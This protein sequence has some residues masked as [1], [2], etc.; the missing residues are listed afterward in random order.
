MIKE[1]FIE[2]DRAWKGSMN[3]P[4]PLR[5]IGGMALVLQYDYKRVTKDAD[6]IEVDEIT[7]QIKSDILGIAGK[8][9]KLHKKYRLY[10]EFLKK[11]FPFLPL[12]PNYTKIADL[13]K[14][15]TNFY[16]EALDA[17][18]VIISKLPRFK[19]PDVDDISAMIEMGVVDKENLDKRFRMAVNEWT[20][21]ARA[22][23]LPKIIENYH[24]IERDMFFTDESKIEL[25]EWI[26][27]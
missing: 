2:L 16:V 24:V 19:G 8:N 4:I 11:A 12:N 14:M 18:D 27:K 6:I 9:S 1:Y 15:L 22:D 23:D 21:D 17:T 25:P 7:E 10:V 13:N 3:I 5:V 26:C 20:C